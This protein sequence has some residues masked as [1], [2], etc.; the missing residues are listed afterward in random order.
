[1]YNRGAAEQVER[2][3]KSHHSDTRYSLAGQV[4]GEISNN[5]GGPELPPPRSLADEIVCVP[6]VP[7][8][9]VEVRL[10]LPAAVQPA[11]EALF[12]DSQS[13]VSATRFV[14][15]HDRSRVPLL[16]QPKHEASLVALRCS[17]DSY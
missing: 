14:Q 6:G 7:L 17:N 2:R 4:E 13:P 5:K 9:L 8:L 15:R 10:K 12:M 3:W 16:V 11:E 1:M